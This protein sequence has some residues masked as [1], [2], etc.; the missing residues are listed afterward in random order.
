MNKL[1][2]VVVFCHP[3]QQPLEVDQRVLQRFRP[4]DIVVEVGL[5]AR[6]TNLV[7][8]DFIRD[9]E[10]WIQIFHVITNFLKKKASK[11][12]KGL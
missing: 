5:D 10:C 2:F 3:R 12:R 9:D 8:I 1:C 6:T 11:Q 4:H 7:F